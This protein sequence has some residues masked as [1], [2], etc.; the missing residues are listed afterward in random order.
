M[1][2]FMND[3]TKRWTYKVVVSSQFFQFGHFTFQ[4]TLGAYLPTLAIC[5]R[6]CHFALHMIYSFLLSV[7]STTCATV[8]R[9]TC[10]QFSRVY[11]RI[12]RFLSFLQTAY[13]DLKR[14]SGVI[15]DSLFKAVGVCSVVGS[16]AF[17]ADSG[18]GRF[19]YSVAPA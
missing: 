12:G 6:K 11:W 9:F 13:T 19:C 4:I 7:T 5:S 14:Q 17:F 10:A 1:Y 2:C 15:S 16:C 3:S 8:V 18:C